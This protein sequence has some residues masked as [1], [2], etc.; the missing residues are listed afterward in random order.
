MNRGRRTGFAAKL[1]KN[2][3]AVQKH[4]LVAFAISPKRS[5]PVTLRCSVAPG[6]RSGGPDG[7]KFGRGAP[8]AITVAYPQIHP[9][10]PGADD[11]RESGLF[12]HSRPLSYDGADDIGSSQLGGSDEISARGARILAPHFNS[13][14]AQELCNP[15]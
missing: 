13:P 9:C 7:V 14:H 6:Q 3:S 1:S 15:A 8:S 4:C 2:S 11:S 12:G 10:P 5:A